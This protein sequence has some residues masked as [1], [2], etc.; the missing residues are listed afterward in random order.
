MTAQEK[1]Y[2]LLEKLLRLFTVIKP[3]EGKAVVLLLLQAFILL[4]AYYLLKPARESLLLSENSAE[5]RSYAV[6][7]QALVLLMLMPAYNILF[8][9]YKHDRSRIYIWVTLFFI[10]NLLLFYV[11]G[12]AEIKLGIVFFIWL[13]VFNVMV[14]AQFWAFCAD[15]YNVESGQRLFVVIAVGA[16]LGA[17]LGASFSKQAIQYTGPLGLMLLA[18][19]LLCITIIL[20]LFASRNLPVQDRSHSQLFKG[21]SK[22]IPGSFHLVFSDRYLLLIAT[23]VVLLNWINSTGEFILAKMVVSHAEGLIAAGSEISKGNLIGSFYGD[24]YTWVNLFSLLFQLLLVSRIFKYFGVRFALYILPVISLIGYGLIVFIPVFS[25]IRLV[26]ILENSVDYS[27]QTT[28]RHT[29]FL[30]VNTAA[31]YEGKTVIDTF[32]WRFGDLIQAGV[33][34]AGTTWLSMEVYQFAIL[35]MILAVVWIGVVVGI[36]REHKKLSAD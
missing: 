19:V 10:C 26:K 30:P 32:F 15:L 20:G 17:L 8:R 27:I 34:Y 28:T 18:V 9:H 3:G 4:F 24:F 12:A 29:L 13:G 25:I 14:V 11:L 33:I 7:F 21:K 1:K 16:S 22:W 2:T 6:A 31:K 5:I 36:T 23:F 35:N